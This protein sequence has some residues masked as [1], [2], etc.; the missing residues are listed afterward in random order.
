MVWTQLRSPVCASNTR[1][2]K[3]VPLV[4]HSSKRPAVVVSWAHGE[5][6]KGAWRSECRT[7][8]A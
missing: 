8:N 4:K 5:P 7:N 1:C 2:R 6:P 3:L